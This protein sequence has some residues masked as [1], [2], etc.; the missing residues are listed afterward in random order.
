MNKN[1]TYDLMN[2]YRRFDVDSMKH[3]ISAQVVWQKSIC[4]GGG[5]S[6]V[7]ISSLEHV[8]IFMLTCINTIYKYCHA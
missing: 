7:Y 6:Q 3:Y 5:G 2:C 8:R 4:S 1:F